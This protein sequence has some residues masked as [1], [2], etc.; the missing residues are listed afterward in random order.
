M[1]YITACLLK[2]KQ[3]GTKQ[4]QNLN[5][6]FWDNIQ[7]PMICYIYKT[8]IYIIQHWTAV[9]WVYSVQCTHCLAPLRGRAVCKN[10][11]DAY[12]F[13]FSIGL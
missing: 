11:C 6:S 13:V 3:D 1:H 5:K 8:Y 12:C 2:L 4:E 9:Y 7:H 10:S